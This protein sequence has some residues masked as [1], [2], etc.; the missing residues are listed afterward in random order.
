M[1][2]NML[3]YVVNLSL[4][5]VLTLVGAVSFLGSSVK[6]VKASSPYYNGNKS[7]MVV[8]IMFNVYGGEE[9][10]DQIVETLNVYDAKAT[11]FIGGVWA[12]KHED[13]IIKLC[14]SGNEIAN[15]GYL[16]RDH[17]KLSYT[18]NKDEIKTAERTIEGICGAKTKLFAPP[19]GSFSADTIKACDDLGYKTIMWSKD[20]IDWRDQNV[21]LIV[22]RATENVLAGDLIL[23]HPTKCSAQAL[24]IILQKLKSKNFQIKTV[25]ENIIIA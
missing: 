19:S 10:L 11:F 1:K 7:N 21:D 17:K 4:A 14:K 22:K 9:Y 12:I 2:K 20:T 3:S 6:T 18:Q 24:P 25:S 15:H 5:L 23:M 16:H 8:S 13:A